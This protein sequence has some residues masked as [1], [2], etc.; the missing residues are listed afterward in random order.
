MN[1]E[2]T[3][4]RSPHLVIEDIEL[5]H[6]FYSFCTFCFLYYGK[7]INFATIFVKILQDDKLKKLY[8]IC[9]SEPSDFEAFRKFIVF[10]PSITKSKYITKVINKNK[11]V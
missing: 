6:S 3:S 5:V 4:N 1:I 11:Q 10:E 2:K 7:K 8:K 9:I